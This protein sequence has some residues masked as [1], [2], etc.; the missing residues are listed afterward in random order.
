M[1]ILE[2]ILKQHAERI[3]HFIA[4]SK[5]YKPLDPPCKAS[6]IK[7]CPFCGEKSYFAFPSGENKEQYAWFCGRNCEASRLPKVETGRD[8]PPKPRRA[9]EWP[10]FCE[11]SGIGDEYHDVKFEDIQQSKGKLDYMIKFARTPK[12]I[13]LMTGDPGTGKTYAC[14]GIC[15]YFTRRWADC[16]FLSQ[17]RMAR[18]WLAGINNPYDNFLDKLIRT[19]L[20]VI[21]DFATG[22]PNPKF[23][24][25]FMEVINSRIQWKERG[26]V[27]TT[28]LDSN[29]F[30]NFCGEAL[31]DRINTGQIMQ[32]DGGSRR[33]KTIL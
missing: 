10:L 5:G 21:D 14:L 11:I 3:V 32:F 2:G 30:A 15:E 31:A 16:I 9:L 23:L 17:K 7:C 27:I 28:N 29:K 25:F 24:E 13:I 12:G 22:E 20:L 8:I 26:T 19:P 33:K 4:T 18:L 6:E 1:T